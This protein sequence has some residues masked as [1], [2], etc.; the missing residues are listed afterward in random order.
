M[1][2]F[3]KTP[4]ETALQADDLETNVVSTSSIIDLNVTTAKL[5]NLNVTTGKLANDSVTG[6]KLDISL[7]AG[8]VIYASG[9]DTMARLAKGTAEQ[10]LTMNAGAT[11]PEWS[12]TAVTRTGGGLPDIG[13][14]ANTVAVAAG[15]IVHVELCGGGGGG[16]GGRGGNPHDGGDGGWGSIVQGIITIVSA[17]V[18]TGSSTVANGTGGAGGQSNNGGPGVDGGDATLTFTPT[19]LGALAFASATGGA[20]GSGGVNGSPNGTDGANGTGTITTNNTY[21]TIGSNALISDGTNGTFNQRLFLRQNFM[22]TLGSSGWTAG[23]GI[24]GAGVTSPASGVPGT[25]GGYGYALVWKRGQL[26]GNNHS[27]L[28]IVRWR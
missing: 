18:I 12:D 3:G 8:D 10:V 16:G 28:W 6:A 5:A 20:G 25:N 9:I 21:W 7:V 19:G 11:A 23:R 2:Y 27:K 17:G 15:D 22:S 26:N 1:P 24:G 4:A 13:V 14:Y